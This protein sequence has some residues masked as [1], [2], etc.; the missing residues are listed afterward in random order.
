VTAPIF[1]AVFLLLIYRYNIN[2]IISPEHYSEKTAGRIQTSSGLVN[3]YWIKI[4]GL[5]IEVQ[6]SQTK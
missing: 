6:V 5:T 1:A 3:I 4:F 2:L